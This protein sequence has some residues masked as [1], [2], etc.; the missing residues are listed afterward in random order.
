[1]PKDMTPEENETEIHK[2]KQ[3]KKSMMLVATISESV[4]MMITQT[5]RPS[6]LDDYTRMITTMEIIRSAVTLLSTFS[7]SYVRVA[8]E[9]LLLDDNEFKE[10][11]REIRDVNINSIDETNANINMLINRFQEAAN[12]LRISLGS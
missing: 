3:Y 10:E 11:I 6:V 9:D 8:S 5:M 4:N 12:H 2:L 1:M 7:K